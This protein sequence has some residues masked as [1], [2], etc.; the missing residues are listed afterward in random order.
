M[1]TDIDFHITFS[2]LFLV[3]V[4]L[5]SGLVW[6]REVRAVLMRLIGLGALV[7]VKLRLGLEVRA[8]LD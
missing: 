7:K 8:V 4:G 1:S 5:G 2:F 3:F 6:R